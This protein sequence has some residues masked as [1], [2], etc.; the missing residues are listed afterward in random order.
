MPGMTTPAPTTTIT[1]LQNLPAALR[2][3]LGISASD[4]DA[5]D[6]LKVEHDVAVRLVTLGHARFGGPVA[7]ASSGTMGQRHKRTAT[8]T[9]DFPSVAA[10]GVQTLPVSVPGAKAGEPVAVR[11][12]NGLDAN[13]VV[14]AKVTAANTVTVSVAN[15]TGG[16]IDP[17]SGSWTVHVVNAARK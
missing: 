14:G 9:L 12:P 13:L 11:P 6:E 15:P 1:L 2:D 4:D 10:G 16:A 3:E 8:A 17:A 5:G 7:D